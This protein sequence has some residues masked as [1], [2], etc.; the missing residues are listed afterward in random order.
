MFDCVGISVDV[1]PTGRRKNGKVE[2]QNIFLIGILKRDDHIR[3]KGE[4]G[5]RQES[6]NNVDC[7]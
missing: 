2:K 1:F 7:G 4:E 3:I 6:L 5:E